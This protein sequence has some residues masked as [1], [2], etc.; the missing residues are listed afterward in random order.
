MG[1]GGVARTRQCAQQQA[2]VGRVATVEHGT[3]VARSNGGRCR[4]VLSR[5]ATTTGADVR[6]LL[7][8]D[9]RSERLGVSCDDRRE[10]VTVE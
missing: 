5:R 1:T 6:D 8:R 4:T 10:S 3:W 7:G 2:E 9:R